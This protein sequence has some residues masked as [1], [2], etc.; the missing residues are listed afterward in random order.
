MLVLFSFGHLLF[1]A[2]A[3]LDAATRDSSSDSDPDEV[4]VAMGKRKATP[5]TPARETLMIVFF[6]PLS[7]EIVNSLANLPTSLYRIF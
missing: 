2:S 4:P 6:Y 1:S 5:A 7:C 3:K